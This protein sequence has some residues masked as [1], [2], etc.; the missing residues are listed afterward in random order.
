MKK[1]PFHTLYDIRKRNRFRLLLLLAACLFL[2]LEIGWLTQKNRAAV[3]SEAEEERVLSAELAGY[4][5]IIP[6]SPAETRAWLL[7]SMG[8]YLTGS[9]VDEILSFLELDSFAETLHEQ[10]P[11]EVEEEITR[12]KWCLLYENLIEYLGLSDEVNIISIRYLGMVPGE[13]RVMTDSGN[14]DCDADS[15]AFTYGEIYEVYICGNILLGIKTDTDETGT[16]TGEAEEQDLS[17]EPV[18]PETVRVLLTQD[19]HQAVYRTTVILKGSTALHL[20]D[21]DRE[22]AVNAD[23][24]VNCTDLMEQW[25]SEQLTVEA[26]E[27][28]RICIANAEGSAVSSYYR[29]RLYLYQNDSGVWIVNEL[30]LEEYLYG[31]VPG[32]MP[33][34]FAAEALQAQAVCARTYVCRKTAAGSYTAFQADVNDTTDCQVYLPSKENE[35]AIQAVDATAGQVL[36]YQGMLAS[37]YYFSTSCGYTSGSEVWQSDAVDY[38]TGVS[39]LTEAWDGADFD[40]FLRDTEVAAYDAG[41]R[42]FRWT[43]DLSPLSGQEALKQ[44]I[45]EELAKSTGKIAVTDTGGASA[46]DTDEASASVTG[47]AYAS[48]TDEASVTDT[49]GAVAA[50]TALLGDYENMTVLQRNESGTV[51]DLQIQFTDASVHIY[52]ENTIRT[53]LGAVMTGLTDKNGD[54]VY[55]F[56]ILPSAAISIESSGDGTCRVYGGGLGHGIGMSQYGANGMAEAGKTCEEILQIFFPGTEIISSS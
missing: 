48:D 36:A 28:G 14:Y 50:D 49:G 19:N 17:A 6:F 11:Y 55:T 37:V 53:I 22:Y 10:I 43:A 54:L 24:A 47:G 41:S 40:A 27:G 8:T 51:T 16:E 23:A 56:S 4:L 42:Y 31:V 33:E 25:E 45:S 30:G 39:M 3:S 38:L 29:G 12:R 13:S 26:E 9:D 52:H 20:S 35:A 2:S 7:P 44:A 15:I 18:V 1:S 34:S 5:Q 32:E 46:S 21:G